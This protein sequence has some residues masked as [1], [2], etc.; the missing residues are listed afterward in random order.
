MLSTLR[1]NA[2]LVNNP[3]RALVSSLLSCIAVYGQSQHT[4]W[5]CDITS[6]NNVNDCYFLDTSTIG[7]L[8]FEDYKVTNPTAIQFDPALRLKE[9]AALGP[10]TAA[11]LCQAQLL[12]PF[13]DPAPSIT[14]SNVKAQIYWRAP[15]PTFNFP[16][17]F[18]DVQF[19]D[20]KASNGYTSPSFGFRM[21]RQLNLD[22]LPI[23]EYR[24]ALQFGNP[25]LQDVAGLPG[26][27]GFLIDPLL[28]NA[29]FL[30]TAPSSELLRQAIYGVFV[31]AQ[32]I[33]KAAAFTVTTPAAPGQTLWTSPEIISLAG[34]AETLIT[35]GPED[36]VPLGPPFK[37]TAAI[38]GYPTCV[39]RDEVLAFIPMLLKWGGEYLGLR[40]KA[41]FH[42]LTGNLRTWA[43]ADAPAMDPT[44]TVGP[45]TTYA[46]MMDV[47]KILGMLW[48]TLRE[49]PALAPSDRELIDNWIATRL[50]P[51]FPVPDFFPNDLGEFGDSIAMADAIRHSDHA[52]FALGIQRFYGSLY[53]MRPDGSFPLSARLSACSTAYS[54]A[55]ISHLVSIAEM[56][57][58]QG[59]DLYH[60]NVDGK[61]LETA[62]NFLLD[63]RDNPA[64]LYQYSRA[65]GGACFEGS[66]GDPPDFDLVFG[67]GNRVNL[68]WAE[69]YL[70]RFPFSATAARLRKI[71]GSNVAATPFPLMTSLTGLNA[72]C[73]FR[74]SYEFQPVN[75]AKVAIVSGDGQTV[76]PDQPDPAPLA[77][78][79]TDN[80][81]KAL[82]GVLVSF[83][84]VQGSASLAT[85]AQVLTD[86]GGMASATVTV[87][88]GPVAV[89]ATAL[90]VSA[91]FS[92]TV[93]E[94]V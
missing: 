39:G 76:G 34:Q 1:Q 45:P 27:I 33:L 35:A 17:E 83:A 12:S 79:V 72:T 55:D 8:K 64:I 36:V 41:S 81:G 13:T 57:A 22:G 23:S 38:A 10:S 91:N 80:S 56:A 74:K 94:P 89:T 86:A 75:G 3:L 28:K 60:W 90:G 59:Y 30:G 88:G 32:S 20:F 87:A 77:V 15:V 5:V 54:N 40:T 52:T 29:T 2:R 63:A 58:T 61:T 78:R 66:P 4:V 69:P 48:P 43:A 18:M 7:G 31:H 11:T 84:V 70:A 21:N 19:T 42:I 9:L 93:P 73:A 62:I 53:Q 50:V 82:A 49:D 14:F 44:N 47:A 37:C 51:P 24:L 71:L 26:S 85:P 67:S 65:G 16:I 92:L 46:L 6:V 25:G 68:A